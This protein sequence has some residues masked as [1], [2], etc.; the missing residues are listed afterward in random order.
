MFYII[1]FGPISEKKE[2]YLYILYDFLEHI[3]LGQS[4]KLGTSQFAYL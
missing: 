2:V 4:K 3:D 1:Q